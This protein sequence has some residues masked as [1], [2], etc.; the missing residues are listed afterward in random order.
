MLNIFTSAKNYLSDA[1]EMYASCRS[2]VKSVTEKQELRRKVDN[3]A[4]TIFAS[5]LK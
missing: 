5:N 3:K 4:L 2:L 1:R